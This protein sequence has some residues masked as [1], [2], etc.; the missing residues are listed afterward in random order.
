MYTLLYGERCVLCYDVGTVRY[1]GDIQPMSSEILSLRASIISKTDKK[2][3]WPILDH[4]SS[5]R[6][7]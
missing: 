6:Y 2:E 1:M 4:F 7:I 5:A 3:I